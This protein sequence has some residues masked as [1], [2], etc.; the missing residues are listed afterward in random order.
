VRPPRLATLQE[1][2]TTIE[3]PAEAKV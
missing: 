1:Q 2:G 3:K